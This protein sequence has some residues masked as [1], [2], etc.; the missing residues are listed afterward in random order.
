MRSF[1]YLALIL[2]F[3]CKTFGESE[4]GAPL[5]RGRMGINSLSFTAGQTFQDKTPLGAMVT[6]TPTILWSMPTFRSRIG[7]HYLADFGSPYG[8]IPIS[9]MGFSGYFYPYGLSTAYEIASDGTLFQKSKPGPYTFATF[10]PVNFNINASSSQTSSGSATSFAAFMI[11]V[12]IG[13]GYDYPLT[14]NMVLSGEL[15]YRF[16]SAQQKSSDKTVSYS[17]LG[18][19]MTFSTSY[20]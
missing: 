3:S 4:S 16:A 14:T 19:M 11:D 18:F 6:L 10:T 2:A 12:G 20:H 15:Q 5:F 13:G 17:G 9:G 1:A 8:F 7:L